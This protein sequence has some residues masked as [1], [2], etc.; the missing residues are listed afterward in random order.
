MENNKRVFV[1]RVKRDYI[2]TYH[3]RTDAYAKASGTA[4]YAEDLALKRNHPDMV[5]MKMLR[6]PYPHARIKSLDTTRAEAVPGIVGVL[7][8]DDPEVL[9]MPAFNS[10]WTDATN[11]TDKN[12]AW[13]LGCED[14]H[15]LS[16]TAQWVGDEMGCAIA[17]ETV[18]AVEEAMKLLDIEWEV[19]PF[20]LTIEDAMKPDAPVLHPDINPDN[21]FIPN[22]PM[23]GPDTNVN[24]GD[25][26]K[27]CEEADVVVEV[28]CDYKNP[29]QCALDYWNC[30]CDWSRKDELLMICDSYAVDQSRI[31]LRDMLGLPMKDIRVIT[32]YEGGQHGRANTGEQMFFLASALMSRKVERPVRYT[33]TRKEHFHDTRTGMYH[34]V[35]LAAMN[36][37][38]IIGVDFNI[39]AN[40]GAYADAS[41]GAVKY[42]A[43][44]WIECMIAAIPSVRHTGRAVYTNIIPASIM[45]SIG[46][47][48]MNNIFGRGIDALAEKLNIDPVEIW[49]KNISC[50]GW[51]PPYNCVEKVIRDGAEFFG[52]DKRHAAGKGE[53]ID[54]TKKRG[55]G[56]SL[57]YTWHTEFQEVRRG[58]IQVQIK[59][60]PDGTVI[61]DAPTVEVGGGSNTC[62]VL[63]CAENLG[64]DFDNIRWI[65]Q[66]DTETGLKD[67]V[68]TDSSVSFVLA[69]SV[70]HCAHKVKEEFLGMVAK[71]L[72]V[73]PKTM[74]MKHGRAFVVDNPEIGMTIPEYYEGIDVFENGTSLNPITNMYV[75][76]LDPQSYGGAYMAVFVEVEIDTETGEIEVTK[77]AVASD[78]GTILFPAGAEGQLAGGQVQGL[79]EA[80]YEE[81]V[82]DD[83]TGIPLNFNFVDYKFPTMADFPDVDPLPME[84]YEGNGEYGACGV[85]E[86]APCCTPGAVGNAIYNA[87]G[88]RIDETAVSPIKI[89]NALG[90]AGE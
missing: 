59:L 58:P 10:E 23:W 70:R 27:A 86:A 38:T 78:G 61:L 32:P 48:Q 12:K 81:M 21:N 60:N 74:D 3:K 66:Q 46:N 82:Y 76:R 6:S 20:C 15:V 44:E 24:W 83:A 84:V 40:T 52:W 14:R 87:L 73:D 62:A 19:L 75:H 28:S 35:K 4:P 16:D 90:K 47:I 41:L 80:L 68:Q 9:A 57:N 49:V 50:H 1:P 67:V 64:V 42:V 63:S 72:G 34:T 69:E 30:M 55:M 17:G 33:Q 25:V 53:L 89:L 39:L 7:R 51:T 85:G 43:P 77:M 79:A 26:D 56:V 29:Q 11:T 54:G 31:F 45:R 88:I 36:D 2:G 65:Y 13:N 8:Y 71:K 22:Y 37:G 18:E 5:Y